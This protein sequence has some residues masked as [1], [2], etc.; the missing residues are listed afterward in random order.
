MDSCHLRIIF[1][2][3]CISSILSRNKYYYI[4]KNVQTSAKCAEYFKRL[5][6]EINTTGVKHKYNVY[7]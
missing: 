5:I 3:N 2:Q 1:C 6:E 4:R 7:M